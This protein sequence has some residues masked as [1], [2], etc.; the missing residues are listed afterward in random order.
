MAIL[1]CSVANLGTSITP[2]LVPAGIKEIR[3]IPAADINLATINAAV[4]TYFDEATYTFKSVQFPLV[5]SKTW[6][7]LKPKFEGAVRTA[8]RPDGQLFRNI[9]ISALR[10]EGMVSTVDIEKLMRNNQ[11]VVVT[12][13]QNGTLLVD[14]LDYNE[15]TE[16]LEIP[17]QLKPM[18]LGEIVD[19]SSTFG[20]AV[21]VNTT[22]SIT[23][24]QLS[25][26]FVAQF[27]YSGMTTM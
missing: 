9:E 4:S 11:L 26:G 6:A 14:G 17:I 25:R 5:V 21:G 18:R 16:K 22:L 24:Q 1:A 15:S 13:L 3:V 10:F 20:D 7:T 8:T 12:L 19:S 23:G 27:A 2:C